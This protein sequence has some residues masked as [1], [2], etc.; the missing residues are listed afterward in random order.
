M[1]PYL[2]TIIAVSLMY[3]SY[4]VGRYFGNQDGISDMVQTLLKIFNAD[5]MEINEDGEFYIT[6]NGQTKKVN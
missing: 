5:S 2:H 4:K 3:C 1:D 6:I